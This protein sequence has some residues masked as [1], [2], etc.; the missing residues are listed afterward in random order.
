[1]RRNILSLVFLAL[2]AAACAQQELPP[3]S[4]G[5]MNIAPQ[6]PRPDQ[7]GVYQVGPGI[8]PPQ[9]K[10]AAAAVWPPDSQP[11]DRPVSCIVSA[12]IDVTGAPTDIKL[13][14][15]CRQG[16]FLASSIDAVKRSQ[17]QPGTLNGKPVPVLVHVAFAYRSPDSPPTP[18]IALLYREG[19]AREGFN[20]GSRPLNHEYD[21]PPVPL[22][23]ANPE[24]SE[25]AR[26][27]RIGGTAIVSVLVNEEGVPIDPRIE[28]GLGHGLDEKALQAA[29]EYRF[30]PATRDGAPVAARITIEM[31]FKLY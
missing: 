13:A 27:D 4:D 24:F 7:N 2:T 19:F 1:M 9:L 28:K 5:P 18:R 6:P 30:R 29:L 16:E 12:V 8:A 10:L 17:F 15:G 31:N 23:V 14:R 25:E 11:L 26:R 21:K 3:A 20:S 22:H